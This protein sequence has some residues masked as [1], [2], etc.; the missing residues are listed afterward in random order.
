M[1]ELC[2]SVFFLLFNTFSARE[3]LLRPG[4]GCVNNNYN[5]CIS[6]PPVRLLTSEAVA[7]DVR[8]RQ[9]LSVI[10]RQVSFKNSL[11]LKLSNE[12]LS[13]AVLGSEFQTAG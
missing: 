7:E 10:T 5:R 13:S 8:S 2:R 4:R 3:V 6:I 12:E 9:S 11:D 1:D